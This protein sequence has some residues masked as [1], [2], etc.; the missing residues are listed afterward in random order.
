M[1]TNRLSIP[2]VCLVVPCALFLCIS[3]TTVGGA[4][5]GIASGGAAALRGGTAGI[6]PQ[7]RSVLERH[8][9]WAASEAQIAKAARLLARRASIGPESSGRAALSE[10]RILDAL[11]AAG[12]KGAVRPRFAAP[13]IESGA[14][15]SMAAGAPANDDCANAI[16]IGLE[17][18]AG[19]TLEATNDG[20]S[21]CDG[22]LAPDI[23]Y[24]F[25]APDAGPF[26]ID[27]FGTGFDSVLSIHSGCPGTEVNQI[28]CSDDNLGSTRANE[29][30]QP[31]SPDEEIFVRVAG[32]Y[33]D[34]VGPTRLTISRPGT[35]AGSVTVEGSGVPIPG[36]E[37]HVVSGNEGVDHIVATSAGDGSYESPLLPP[38]QTYHAAAIGGGTH[39]VNEL[40]DGRPCFPDCNLGAGAPITVPPAG[41]VAGIDFSLELGGLISGTVTDDLDAPLAGVSVLIRTATG[42]VA[43]WLATEADGTYESEIGLPTG[44]YRVQTRN[45]PLLLDELYDDLPCAHDCNPVPGTP[46]AVTAGA[47]TTGID[48]ELAPGGQI[49]G[50]LTV[51]GSGDPLAGYRID[52]YDADGWK[53]G[54][55]WTGAGGTYNSGFGL[56]TGTFYV[57]ADGSSLYASEAWSDLPCTG[58]ACE[59][60]AGD[61]VA[62]TLGETTGGIDFALAP[63]GRVAGTVTAVAGGVPL[64]GIDVRVYD[65]A[66]NHVD[67][68][69][70]G[71]AGTYQTTRAL[72][73]G[74]YHAVTRSWF[75]YVDK[76]N[77]G[78]VCIGSC[79]PTAGAGFGVTAPSTTSG[80]DF[81][82]DAGGAIAGTVL[83]G[84]TGLPPTGETW[85]T[86]WDLAGGEIDGV[87]VFLDGTY[88]FEGG[89]PTGAYRV[90]AAGYGLSGRL[91]P[92]LP[93]PFGRCPVAGGTP[94]P[95]VAPETTPAIDF[96]LGRPPLA[97]DGFE[98]SGFG[99]WATGAGPDPL[100]SHSFCLPGGPL[101]PA[102]DPCVTLIG[103]ELPYCTHEAWYSV[104]V[105]ATYTVCGIATCEWDQE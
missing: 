24:R 77:D 93:C 74:V 98:S 35:F 37:I 15:P 43:D 3:F 66:G 99:A 90:T 30:W 36:I 23:W 38:G 32:Y 2:T 5:T 45:T 71:S 91:F 78:A 22:D 14:A 29:L 97:C 6:E 54:Q 76:R 84:E 49:A 31:S 73:S 27:T 17:S 67:T 72:P 44:S 26:Y 25:T 86:I 79:D 75:G 55:V 95:V 70:S 80:I 11:R 13:G 34:Y 103:A 7:V 50:T 89:L 33:P 104:C 92:E 48:F 87:E 10:Q 19:S 105:E 8:P 60:T 9:E 94:V 58:L 21:E 40:Y 100:C 57:L 64:E 65:A 96:E 81:A 42:S 53:V 51:A 62:V 68:G 56:P 20:A 69:W 41:S 85:V 12:V 46:V 52:F 82:L 18:V 28:W 4:A 101:V 61:G 16:V 102:C 39:Y 1:R 63:G 88:L 83:D 47:T 59:P